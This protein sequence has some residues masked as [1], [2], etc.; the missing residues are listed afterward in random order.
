MIACDPSRTV[1]RRASEGGGLG[2]AWLLPGIDRGDPV[3]GVHVECSLNRV[4]IP[5]QRC[6]VVAIGTLEEKS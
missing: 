2:C 5:H 4:L 3:L 1:R 6:S